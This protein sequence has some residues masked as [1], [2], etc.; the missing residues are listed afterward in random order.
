MLP[1]MKANTYLTDTG[2]TFT[3]TNNGNVAFSSTSSPF[4]QQEFIVV[5]YHLMVLANI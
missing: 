5:V 3:V 4:Y 2:H 1:G